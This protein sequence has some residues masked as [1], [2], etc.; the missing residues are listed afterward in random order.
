MARY[1]KKRTKSHGQVP[2][3]LIFIGRK[4]MD[5]S[6]VELFTYDKESYTEES[7]EE[8]LPW[9]N[10]PT[11]KIRWLNI[12][13]LQDTQLVEK[14]GELFNLSALAMEDILNTDQRPKVMVEEQKMVI[15]LKEIEYNSQKKQITSDHVTIIL[16]QGYVV[17]FQERPGDP[18]E[19]IR[20]RIR[21]NK[22]KIRNMGVDYLVFS[23]IDTLV[24]GYIQK[25]E[26]LG[27]AMEELEEQIINHSDK[28]TLPQIYHYKKEVNFMRKSI[29]PMNEIMI[30]LINNEAALFNKRTK[31]YLND[32]DDLVHQTL[33]SI[34]IYHNMANDL[35][36]LYHANM[37]HRGNEVMRTLTI[38]ASIFIPLTFLVGVYG[39]NFDNLPEL[40]WK[41]GYFYMWVFMI[42]AVS[43]MMFYFRRKKWF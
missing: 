39:T 32:L 6:R 42:L 4:K 16:G 27:T 40:H 31:A 43:G 36:N 30:I 10:I 38:F 11:T 14:T 25:I 7:I 41:Y 15:F 29:R 35:I 18:F 22:G 9:D 33:E 28:E 23:L 3:S 5:E 2:G 1:I 17:T 20:D 21:N 34:E 8:L 12:C 24:D 13:G 19:P 37:T 26:M